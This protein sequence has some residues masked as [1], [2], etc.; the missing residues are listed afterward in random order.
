V[1]L[2]QNEIMD[3]F[4]DDYRALSDSDGIMGNRSDTSLKVQLPQLMFWD[5]LSGC[6]W[7][8]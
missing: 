4:T 7:T 3:P 5:M 1:S 2:Q 6:Q 8:V